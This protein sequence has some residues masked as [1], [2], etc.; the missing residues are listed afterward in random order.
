M[1]QLVGHHRL[2]REV[3]ASAGIGQ[4]PVGVGGGADVFHG[5]QELFRHDLRVFLVRVVHAEALGIQLQHARRVVEHAM[6]VVLA[7]RAHVVVHR[8]VAPG[9]GQLHELAGHQRNEVGRVRP[10]AA[11]LIR[12]GAI[13]ILA[14]VSQRAIREREEAAR[15]GRAERGGGAVVGG[16]VAREPVVVVLGLPL[17]PRLHRQVW[18]ARPWLDEREPR[19]RA[20]RVVDR[21]RELLAVGVGTRQAHDKLFALRPERQGSVL[22]RQRD[23]AN[24]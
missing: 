6:G 9:V 13:G 16:V 2:W 15:H 7:A 22:A 4:E 5:A 1:H 3:Q 18:I 11:P 8:Q 23:T 21:D 10:L 19:A 14:Y 24:V 20:R 12:L 17:G